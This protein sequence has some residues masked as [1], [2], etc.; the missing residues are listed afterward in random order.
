MDSGW[1]DSAQAWIDRQGLTGDWSRRFVLDPVVL[2]LIRATGCKSVLDVGCG[3][4]RLCRLLA[5][6]NLVCTGIDPTAA[7]LAR[8]QQLDS[9]SNYVEGRAEELPFD[10]SSFDLVVSYLSLID[11]ENYR[12]GIAE[13]CRVLKPGGAVMV[14]NLNGLNTAGQATG[15]IKDDN[16][17]P[18]HY[19]IDNYLSEHFD[20]VSWSGIRIRNWHRPLNAY[21]KAFLECGLQLSFFDEPRSLD[22]D[23][24]RSAIFN[25]A[26]YFVVMQWLKPVAPKL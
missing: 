10:D 4:G 5:K 16:G 11:I 25:R 18:Q 8:A 19:P 17:V 22:P 9:E 24:G 14:V 15:W 3:E 26:P 20:W 21:M 23:A 6:E 2:P 12:R 13:M 7:L 1:D